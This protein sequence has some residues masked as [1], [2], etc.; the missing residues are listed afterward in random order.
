MKR[1]IVYLA[2]LAMLGVAD[3][4]D[5]SDLCPVETVWVA[6]ENGQI[7]IRTDAG[8]L[9]VGED[10]RSAV[11]N[12]N[13]TAAGIAFL[14]TADYLIIETGA[15]EILLQAGPVLRP[16][17]MLCV[18][19]KMPDLEAATAYLRIHEP[20]VT[21]RQWSKEQAPLPQLQ[22]QD[23]RFQLLAG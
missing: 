12:L 4:M 10:L 9:G 23:G 13:A 22:E 5:I 1:W 8:D 15:E 3:G 11:E 20:V 2:V 7:H 16:S 17:C 19:E 6:R 18:A 21:L 14:E